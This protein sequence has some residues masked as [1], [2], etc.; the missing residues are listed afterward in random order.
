MLWFSGAHIETTAQQF[1]AETEARCYAF[2]IVY[3]LFYRIV[4]CPI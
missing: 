2:F 4:I 3:L 1:A